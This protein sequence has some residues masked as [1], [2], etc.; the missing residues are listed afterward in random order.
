MSTQPKS[1][2]TPEEYLAM[3]RKAEYKSEYLDGEVFAMSGVK[4]AHS[5]IAANVLAELRDGLRKR[6]CEAHGSDLR[7][8]TFARHYCYPDVSA[9]CG[10]PQFLDGQLDTLLNPSLIVEVV[11]PS[12]EAYDRGRK[13]EFYQ[14]IEVL[15]DY[16][17]LASDR[18]HG[19]L[20]TRQSDGTWVRRSF[21]APEDVIR[22][23]S[24]DCAL[25]LA[26]IYEKADFSGALG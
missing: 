23:A 9:F 25:K 13:F 11:S 18:M 12:T 10:E 4:R 6:Q 20:Y 17:L 24:I 2:I 14:A 16:L 15:R 21:S 3:E 22:I 1:F 26:D 8:R 7:V 19:D 5:L